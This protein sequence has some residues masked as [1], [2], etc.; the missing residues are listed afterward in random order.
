M[1]GTI[2]PLGNQFP[3]TD[4]DGNPTP[5]FIRWA[6]QRQIDI[7]GGVTIAQVNQAI[8]DWSDDRDIIAGL[9]LSGGGNLSH[10]VTINLDATL[11]QLTD[12]SVPSPTN[13]QALVWDSGTSLWKAATVANPSPLTTKGDL[14]THSTVDTRLP[15]GTDGQLLTA[16]STQ[17]T[18][19][20]W[21]G[22]PSASLQGYLAGL[23]LSTVGSS[24][25]FTVASGTACNSTGITMISLSSSLSKTTSAWVAG[26]SN[27]ALDTGTIINGSWYHIFVIAKVGGASP[28]VLISLSPSTPTLPATYTLFRRIGSMNCN[29]SGQWTKFYQ[30]GNQFLYD[31]PVSAQNTVGTSPSPATFQIA[32]PLGI[33]TEAIL[34]AQLSTTAGPEGVLYYSVIQ[35]T[36]TFNVPNGNKNLLV[37][38]ITDFAISEIN[39]FTDTNSTIGWVSFQNVGVISSVVKG[40]VDSRGAGITAGGGGG[41]GGGAYVKLGEIITSGGQATATFSTIPQGYRDLELRMYARGSTAA[42]SVEA[43]IQFNGDTGNN[44]NW[45]RWNRTGTAGATPTNKINI[46]EIPA[47]TSPANIAGDSVS[48]IAAYTQTTFAK[49]ATTVSGGRFTAGSYPQEATGDWTSTAAIT[50]I[51]VLL[52]AGNFVNGSIITLY[53]RN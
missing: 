37:A 50:S 43:Y 19:L 20:K 11:D 1:A 52:A 6:Q 27:G 16:D 49:R 13:G 18:G 32:V 35:P 44:Y 46:A 29:G 3:I 26:A 45:L 10:D 21:G 33:I 41:S 8:E 40:W 42:T 31:V 47:S 22:A 30:N 48:N 5:Y 7:Q 24:A 38:G 15:V 17:T 36:P 25:T 51:L 34:V 4:K 39:L 53:G 9:G 2:Q 28:D 23:E 12:V 14:F